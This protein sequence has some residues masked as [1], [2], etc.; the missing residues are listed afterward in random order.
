MGL[1]VALLAY[2][3][4][5]ENYTQLVGSDLAGNLLLAGWLNLDRWAASVLV[6]S[7]KVFD[8][9][10]EATANCIKGVAGPGCITS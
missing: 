5:F 9:M 10:L 1:F 2:N 6:V 8:H 3:S 4:V 7:R